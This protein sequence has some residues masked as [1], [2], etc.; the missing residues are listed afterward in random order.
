MK[1]ALKTHSALE[2]ITSAAWIWTVEHAPDEINATFVFRCEFDVSAD[3]RTGLILTLAADSRYRLLVN[4]HVVGDG[5][6]RGYPDVL[7]LD[8]HP[9]AP[10][11]HG[12][13]NVI[14]V[15]VT[16]L[17]VD[18]FQY[19]RGAPG[20]RAAVFHESHPAKPLLATGSNWRVRRARELTRNS[21]RISCQQG[22]EEQFDARLASVSQWLPAMLCPAEWHAGRSLRARE[23][24][25]LGHVERRVGHVRHAGRIESLPWRWTFAVRDHFSPHPLGANIHGMAGVLETTFTNT[26]PVT[27]GI[28]VLGEVR[29]LCVDGVPLTMSWEQQLGRVV[30]PLAS[31][32]HRLS[33]GVCSANDHVGELAV[34][35]SVDA[36]LA[37]AASWSST[38]PLWRNEHDSNC[39]L[40][41]PGAVSPGFETATLGEETEALVASLA[42]GATAV[43]MSPLAS[44]FIRAAD[45]YFQVRTDHAPGTLPPDA[46]APFLPASQAEG[47]W[48]IDAEGQRLLVDL[49]QPTLGRFEI[50]L[51]APANTVVD[52]YFFE[53]YDVFADRIKI[54]FTEHCRNTSRYVAREGRNVFRSLQRRGF[55][56]VLLTFRHVL[57]PVVVRRIRVVETTWPAGRTAGFT[58]SDPRLDRIHQVSLRT[59]LLCM[60]D[61]FTDCPTYEQALWTGDTRNEALCASYGFGASDIMQR[62]A[63]LTADSLRHLPLAA[64]QCPSGWDVIIPSFSF[65]WCISVW[66]IYLH[67]GDVAFL[68]GIYPAIKKNLHAAVERC[69][70]GGLFSAPAWHFLDWTNIDCRHDT[71]SHD[72]M[73]LAAALAAGERMAR[74]LEKLG[75]AS[76]FEAEKSR[77]KQAI[78]SLWLDHRRAFSDAR[79]ASGEL[80]PHVSQHTSFLALLFDLLPEEHVPFAIANLENPPPDMAE[81]GSPNAL[82]LLLDALLKA[83]RPEQVLARLR[84]SWGR[85]L[86]A[87]ALTF[88]EMIDQRDKEFPTRSRCH[89]WAASPLYLLPRIFFEI[90]I[91]EPGWRRVAVSPRL[92]GL[93]FVRLS[94]CTPHGPLHLSL[95]QTGFAFEAPR[96]IELIVRE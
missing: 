56:H 89:G 60:E 4:A 66:E 73:L 69:D 81:T 72:S 19:V 71:V 16:H 7:C 35:I 78:S 55:R 54:Q 94:I 11:L 34:G 58:S 50:E 84:D 86:D 44:R 5:P 8:S 21:P 53:H 61:T 31:G 2:A 76:V 88:W 33:I 90:E 13:L 64:S 65:M 74:V 18:T 40:K 49:D 75:D 15:W 95:D 20:L 82:F 85:M 45:I 46:W 25:P 22:F 37:W 57:A 10:F 51:Q 23:V 3:S 29:L 27:L 91:I 48:L 96:Q 92:L 68:K 52:A 12:G 43:P 24:P 30:L 47:D 1:E 32:R 17:G 63:M 70:D 93:E 9:L 39:P 26:T 87:G 80:S 59:L 28:C 6:G 79:I 67:T 42:T 38:G 41:T 83:G 36:A 77:L 14:E 62:S